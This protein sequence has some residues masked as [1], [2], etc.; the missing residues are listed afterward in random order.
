M[1]TKLQDIGQPAANGR[2]RDR[3]IL[4]AAPFVAVAALV[5]LFGDNLHDPGNAGRQIL[6]AAGAGSLTFFCHERYRPY[7]RGSFFQELRRGYPVA[8][9]LAAFGTIPAI[10]IGLNGFAAFAGCVGYFLGYTS[11]RDQWRL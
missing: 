1:G 8:A 10:L 9:A 5:Y 7:V 4:V 2:K 6:I 3:A 11:T